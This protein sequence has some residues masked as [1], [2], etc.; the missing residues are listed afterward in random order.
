MPGDSVA[1]GRDV[2]RRDAADDSGHALLS[3][4]GDEPRLEFLDRHT[5]LLCAEVLHVQPEDAGEFGE[6]VDVSA[7]SEQPEDVLVVDGSLLRRAQSIPVQYASSSARNA[8]R[9][10]A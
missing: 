3:S 4:G 6:V 10:S 5:R 7:E 9:F 1:D 2:R 8:A